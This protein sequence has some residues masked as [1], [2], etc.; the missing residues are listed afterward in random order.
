MATQQEEG[1]TCAD[2]LA[3][4]F[5]MGG[6]IGLFEYCF[7]LIIR[8]GKPGEV[9]FALILAMLISAAFASFKTGTIQLRVTSIAWAVI[10]IL[11]MIWWWSL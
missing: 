9:F 11:T 8:E 4:G 7:R 5:L 2:N 3:H 1:M 10:A 6:I